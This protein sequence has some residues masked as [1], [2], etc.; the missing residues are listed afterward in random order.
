MT[1]Q[2]AVEY[3]DSSFSWLVNTDVSSCFVLHFGRTRFSFLFG[4]FCGTVGNAKPCERSILVTIKV[5]SIEQKMVTHIPKFQHGS[6]RPQAAVQRKRTSSL[7]RWVSVLYRPTE[8]RTASFLHLAASGQHGSRW[9]EGELRDI[10]I[11]GH[12]T[13]A[14]HAKDEEARSGPPERCV[15]IRVE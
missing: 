8:R 11:T 1:I 3:A 15:Q 13:P 9:R 5:G 14:T 2:P 7:V 6:D 10:D 12:G 4:K